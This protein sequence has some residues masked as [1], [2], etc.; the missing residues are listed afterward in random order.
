MAI[1]NLDPKISPAIQ[2]SVTSSSI[3]ILQPTVPGPV[4][5]FPSQQLSQATA[6]FKTP[7]TQ[8]VLPP[9]ASLQSSPAR[10]EGEVPES[11][12]DPDTRRR[13]LILQHGQDSR[14]RASSASQ[15]P[16]RA[17]LQVSAPRAQGHDWF[18]IEEEM[19]PRQVNRV[20]PPKDFPL[21]SEPMEIEKHRS[22]HA[23]FLPKA[24]SVVPPD[25]VFLENQ[26]MLKEVIYTCNLIYGF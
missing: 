5:P 21:I 19:S 23:P 9:E 14:D 22:N 6:V 10:E 7:I 13:L 15:F 24:E 17:P 16:V 4:V 11:E 26:R 18:P 25:R 20:V 1:A 2:Y 12:L 3:P 8:V